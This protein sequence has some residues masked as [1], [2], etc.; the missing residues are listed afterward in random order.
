MWTRGER[1]YDAPMALRT[2]KRRLIR[3]FSEEAVGGA[4]ERVP[5]SS[6]AVEIADLVRAERPFPPLAVLNE[7]FA[8]GRAAATD[9][10][11]WTGDVTRRALSWE[12]FSIARE[13]Y[14][15]LWLECVTDPALRLLDEEAP[16]AI[17]TWAA[18]RVWIAAPRG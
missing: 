2:V 17:D 18:W 10:R 11:T 7:A 3:V 9:A 12:P 8:Q 16:A 1:A 4:L 6:L 13:E 14:E 5:V 15:A